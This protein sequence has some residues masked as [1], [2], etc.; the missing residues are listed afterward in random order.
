MAPGWGR[1]KVQFGME[2]STREPSDQRRRC[3]DCGDVIGVYE[4]LV[5]VIGATARRTSLA[6]NPETCSQDG[7]CYHA[8][9]YER[10]VFGAGAP[11]AARIEDS[12]AGLFRRRD[13][14]G[15]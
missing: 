12:A 7:D 10:L 9:C 1:A 13:L 11:D 4:P 14:T 6:A 3:A 8:G 15:A 5:H 2:A